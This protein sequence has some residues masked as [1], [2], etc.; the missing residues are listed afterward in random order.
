MNETITSGIELML[1]G[2]GIVFLFLA[3]LIVAVN[4]MST[5]IQHYFSPAIS[6]TNDNGIENNQAIDS[7]VIA[8][9]T[10]AIHQYR[11]NFPK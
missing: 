3:M 5:V 9:I 7:N 6:N 8:A 11:R 1:T 4:V 2:M 10:A